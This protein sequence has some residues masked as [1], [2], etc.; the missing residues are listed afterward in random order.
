MKTLK[1]LKINHLCKEELATREMK[2]VFGGACGCGCCYEGFEGGASMMEN[3]GANA[4]DN[5]Y[6][7]GCDNIICSNY[8]PNV[9]GYIAI[10]SIH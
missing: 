10:A 7:P 6:S 2:T 5:L 9:G 8:D 3:S 1:R 4:A